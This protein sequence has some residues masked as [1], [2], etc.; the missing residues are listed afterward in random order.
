MIDYDGFRARKQA[1]LREEGRYLGIGFSPF[2]EPT[3]WGSEVAKATASPSSSSTR[4]SVTM[5]P[6]GSVIV[7]TGLHN[8]G[9]AH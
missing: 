3:A 7:T 6:D 2:V 4:R 8:H 9:Q 1:E 5:E